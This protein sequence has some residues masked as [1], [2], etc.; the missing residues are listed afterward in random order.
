MFSVQVISSGSGKPVSGKR[1]SVSFD[2]LLRGGG[3][4]DQYTD[5]QG[6]VHF[7]NDPGDGTV[8]VN[9]KSV[10][11]GRISGRVVVYV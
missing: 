4:G 7:N 10:H 5:S 3:T 2:A 6:E 1:V 9:G 11:K 8:Y